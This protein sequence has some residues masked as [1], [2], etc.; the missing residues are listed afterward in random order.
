[1]T[2]IQKMKNFAFLFMLLLCGCSLEKV[3]PETAITQTPTALVATIPVPVES[4]TLTATASP[5]QTTP[6]PSP[7]K[8]LT[9]SPSST[10]PEN[11]E[12]MLAT[13]QADLDFRHTHY[14][15]TLEARGAVCMAGY[16]MEL[17]E[18]GEVQK[19][20]NAQWMVFTCS[21]K[22]GEYEKRYTQVMRNDG[23][24]T[25]KISH[26][27]F[28]WSQ[29]QDALLA[30]YR[31]THDGRYLYLRP[32]TYPSP[33]GGFTALTYFTRGGS[34]LYR[35]NLETGE[36]ESILS[37][38]PRQL[39]FVLSPDDRYLIYTDTE[40]KYVVHIWD[41]NDS[42]EIQIFQLEPKYILAGAYEWKPDSSMVIFAAAI[43][44]WD[45]GKAGFS[46]FKITIRN[47]HMQIILEN[48]L[49]LFIPAWDWKIG[50]A[51]WSDNNTL[52]LN[53]HAE[54]SQDSV[55]AID[56]RTGKVLLIATPTPRVTFTPTP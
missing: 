34:A 30:T 38:N 2:I 52:P 4:P 42:R 28:A 56:V 18:A 12:R 50:K 6:Q 9:P 47:M 31:W 32:Y 44:G 33:S 15:M 49:R 19:H 29:R 23:T 55:W 17:L 27:D 16:R 20:S 41:V 25:W 43:D 53:S 36:F 37:D 51:Q 21:P 46:L 35:L 3:L 10:I 11:I 1:M 54:S 8:T 22:D 24:R 39:S 14:P 40:E 45:T 13:G 48:D 26:R 7:T 5:S